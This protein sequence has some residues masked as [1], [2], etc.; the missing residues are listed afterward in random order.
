ML[1]AAVTPEIKPAALVRPAMC[2]LEGIHAIFNGA[3][4]LEQSADPEGLIRTATSAP[5]HQEKNLIKSL[6]S[7]HGRRLGRQPVRPIPEGVQK[8]T[9]AGAREGGCSHLHTWLRVTW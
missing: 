4:R 5:R 6:T 8:C 7:A 2:F 1:Y 3:N 9:V